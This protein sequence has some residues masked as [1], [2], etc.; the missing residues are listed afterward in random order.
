MTQI[1]FFIMELNHYVNLLE[2]L[3]IEHT[4]SL[5]SNNW[6]VELVLVVLQTIGNTGHISSCVQTQGRLIWQE[7]YHL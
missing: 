7:Y 1:K 6:C 4:L 3:L 2:I 5:P